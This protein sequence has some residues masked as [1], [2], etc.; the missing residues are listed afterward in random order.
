MALD[1]IRDAFGYRIRSTE[2]LM[3]GKMMSSAYQN[4]A[5]GSLLTGGMKAARVYMQRYSG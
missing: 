2:D 1:T 4:E 5:V 3:Q